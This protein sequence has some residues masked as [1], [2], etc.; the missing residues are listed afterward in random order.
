MRLTFLGIL[1][2]AGCRAG[3]PAPPVPETELS[4]DRGELEPWQG[5]WETEE[6]DRIEVRG[7]FMNWRSHTGSV[8]YG[9]IQVNPGTA[10]IDCYECDE[11]GSTAPVPQPP[12]VIGFKGQPPTTV[13]QDP[14]ERLVLKGLFR[15]DGDRLIWAR[16]A[17]QK[18][19]TDFEHAVFLTTLRRVKP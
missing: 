15:R 5:K 9:L 4:P 17:D 7:N 12:F 6:H 18:R 11:H 14:L 10:E 2:L 3:P 16:N 13:P 1:V 8:S 19:P